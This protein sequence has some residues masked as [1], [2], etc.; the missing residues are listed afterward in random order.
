MQILEGIG[1]KQALQALVQRIELEPREKLLLELIP[2]LQAMTGYKAGRQASAW[3]AYVD[4][5]PGDW[6]SL[7][8]QAQDADSWSEEKDDGE[9]SLEPGA[10]L[11]TYSD[12]IVYLLDFSGSIWNVGENGKS[13]KQMLDPLFHATLDA[14]APKALFNLAPFTKEVKPW[15]PELVEASAKR[16]KDAHKFI[17][18]VK[19][20][21]PGDFYAAVQWAKQ[22]PEIDTICVLTDGAPTGG[23][24]W[25]ME[26]MVALLLEEAELRPIRFDVVLVDCPKGLTRHWQR[27]ADATGG[28]LQTNDLK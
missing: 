3:K 8:N 22:D 19:V 24:R 5:L 13:S 1:D 2:R 27:L 9:R 6:T 12:R 23:R 17:E 20:T 25:N 7:P 10:G 28:T 21:G 16:V 11:P 15:Q 14:I 4:D 26:W 18:N